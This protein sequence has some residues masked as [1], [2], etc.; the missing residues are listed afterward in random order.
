MQAEPDLQ[1]HRQHVLAVLAAPTAA[2]L[3][4]LMVRQQRLRQ[5]RA[6]A[7]ANAQ[8]ELRTG[9]EG[10]YPIGLSS[11]EL[12]RF[13]ICVVGGAV[14]DR[15]LGCGPSPD[16]DCVVPAQRWDAFLAYVQSAGYRPRTVVRALACKLQDGP[17]AGREFVAT[18]SDGYAVGGRLQHVEPVAMAG[19]PWRRD[20]TLQALYADPR[21]GAL[22]DPFGAAGA[23]QLQVILPGAMAEDPLRVVRLVRAQLTHSLPVEAQTEREARAVSS[24][25]PL[26]SALEGF[27]L[28]AELDRAARAGVLGPLL[29][30]LEL[31]HWSG[32]RAAD[33]IHDAVRA[34]SATQWL[35]RAGLAA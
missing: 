14:R 5:A 13:S 26:T 4:E 18:R 28:Q 9:M 16:L 12:E 2:A 31:W 29:R 7:S 15:L 1:A 22:W 33:P 23:R 17:A 8:F 21:S 32:L 34:R 10:A 30:T 6:M 27:R 24:C 11:E 19:D 35:R 3:D 20:F 25:A